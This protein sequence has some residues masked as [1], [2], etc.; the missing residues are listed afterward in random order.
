MWT[1]TGSGRFG[2][3]A[4]VDA[5]GGTPR[6]RIQGWLGGKSELGVQNRSVQVVGVSPP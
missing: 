1:E 4:D 2:G 3:L 5:V 6:T